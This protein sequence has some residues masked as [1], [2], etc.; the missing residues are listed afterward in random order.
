LFSVRFGKLSAASKSAAKLDVI[1]KA[2]K[3]R[4]KPRLQLS[5]RELRGWSEAF[6][7]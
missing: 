7:R 5:V 6:R 4:L 2:A 1:K 3:S